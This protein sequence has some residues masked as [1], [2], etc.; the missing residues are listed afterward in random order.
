MFIQLYNEH[1]NVNSIV[2]ISFYDAALRLKVH[3]INGKVLD[4]TAENKTQYNSFKTSLFAL[5]KTHD[6]YSY[7]SL[8]EEEK[9][10]E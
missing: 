3:L 10:D 5:S 8:Y 7:P 6:G 4:V 2:N 9:D 1:V